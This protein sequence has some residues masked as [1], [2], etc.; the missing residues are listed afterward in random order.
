MVLDTHRMA[1]SAWRR[2]FATAVDYGLVGAWGLLLAGVSL[3]AGGD[4]NLATLT[5]QAGQLLGLL[6]MTVPATLAIAVAEARGGSP[7]KRLLGLRLR[8]VGGD[9]SG[10]RPAIVRTLGKVTLPWELAHFGVWHFIAGEG[11]ILAV[12]STALAYAVLGV[13]AVGVLRG[14]PWYDRLAGTRVVRNTATAES[15]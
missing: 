2:A 13:A 1:T 7:G 8:A 12:G 11:G 4:R 5:P 3:G 15:D 10:L 6:T 14:E 9:N